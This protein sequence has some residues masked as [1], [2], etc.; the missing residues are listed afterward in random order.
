MS[1]FNEQ[2]DIHVLHVS[3]RSMEDPRAGGGERYPES[4]VTALN[5]LPNCHAVLFAW[6]PRGSHALPLKHGLVRFAHLVGKADLVHVHQLNSWAFDFCALLNLLSGKPLVVSDHGGGWRNPGR[7]LGPIRYRFA[8]G[9]AAVSDW[10]RTSDLRWPV[11]RPSALLYGGGASANWSLSSVRPIRDMSASDFLFIG[12]VVPHKGVDLLLRALPPGNSLRIVGRAPD[13]EYATELQ[14]II[15]RRDIDVD[16]VLDAAD[17]DVLAALD[18]TAYLVLP[19]KKAVDGKSIRRPE[20]L[21]LVLLEAFARGVPTIASDAGALAEVQRLAGLPTFPAG[22][23]DSLER[24][25]RTVPLERSSIEYGQMT[26]RAERAGR[27]FSW[28]ATAER[29]FGLYEEVLGGFA[30][31]TRPRLLPRRR[32]GAQ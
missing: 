5:H 18:A 25:L 24:M 23:A 31:R 17:S 20:L 29:C 6:P 16:F 10:S 2:T 13:R 9:L 28:S 19:T 27:T 14:R 21:G 11:H 22:D 7:L 3:P 1:R 15:E 26:R 8:D 12:R 30:S 32:H 4:L